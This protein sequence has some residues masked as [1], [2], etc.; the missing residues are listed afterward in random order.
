MTATLHLEDEWENHS[1]HRTGP[2]WSTVHERTNLTRTGHEK[3]PLGAGKV[4]P[5]IHRL[6]SRQS[7]IMVDNS[8]HTGSKRCQG[9]AGSG[10]TPS[11]G[12]NANTTTADHTDCSTVAETIPSDDRW[13]PQNPVKIL[14]VD[15]TRGCTSKSTRQP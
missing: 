1:T 8:Y 3:P 9:V 12:H 13:T 2:K 4:G 7:M 10:S 14:I 6:P 5:F 15:N 11:F